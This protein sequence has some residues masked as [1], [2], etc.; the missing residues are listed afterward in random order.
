M[1]NPDITTPDWVPDAV[2]Y[3][4]FPDRFAH[5]GRIGGLDLE[6]WDSPPTRHGF[7]GG[8]LWGVLEK[9]DYLQELGANAIYFC[10]VFQSAANHRYH[11]HDYWRVDPV[12]GGNKALRALLDAAHARG[13]RVVLDGV[14]NHAS[15]GFFQFNHILENGAASPYVDWFTIKGYPL[16]AYSRKKPPNYACWWDKRELPEFNTDNPT[17]RAFLLDVARHWIEFGVDGWRLD[18]PNEIDDDAFWRQFRRVVKEA[19][20]QAYIVG[21]IWGEGQRWLQGDQFDAVMNY[22]WSRAVLSFTLGRELPEELRPGQREIKPLNA[23]QFAAEIERILTLHPREITCAQLNLLGSHDTARFLTLAQGETA[24]LKLATLLQMTYPGAPCIYYGDEIGLQG[25]PDPNCRGAFPWDEDRWDQDLLAYVRR[26]TALRHALAPLRRGALV[27]LYAGKKRDVYV[28]ARRDQG[29]T[30]LVAVNGD[31]RKFKRP[32][33]AGEIAWPDGTRLTDHLS[34]GETHIEVRDGHITGLELAPLSG[35]MLTP[36]DVEICKC[37]NLKMWYLYLLTC[38]DGVT[39]TGITT[40]PHR[41]LDEHNAGRGARFTRPQKRRPVQF[42]GCW[43]F[44]DRASATRAEA[45]FKRLKAARKRQ[46]AAE[47][48]PFQDAPFCPDLID[49]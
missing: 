46:L 11:T 23:R 44:P 37:S 42:L 12:L 6:P 33:P 4:I 39:Y 49:I 22:V 7:K 14:F 16:R 21:E 5:S 32:I 18:V 30:V 9:L 8:D 45:R 10:P 3:Q 13:M 2:F 31:K 28:F 27:S 36:L 35:A 15:R 20:P 29:Q 47:Q 26:L 19:N 40:D 41:R 38:A 48:R 43:R 1:S 25:G 24:R 34:M 17:A